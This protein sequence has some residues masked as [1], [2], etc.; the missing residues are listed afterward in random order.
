[1]HKLTLYIGLILIISGCNS[2]TKELKF[3]EVKSY[4]INL[5]KFVPDDYEQE[6]IPYPK[7]D[8]ILFITYFSSIE[9]LK[10]YADHTSS[11]YVYSKNKFPH[12][13]F[14]ITLMAQDD[15]FTKK[16]YLILLDKE[17]KIKDKYLI[18]YSNI[19]EEW[20]DVTESK[21][22]H[23]TLLNTNKV[24]CEIL[25]H[26]NEIN[27]CNC[28]SANITIAIKPTGEISKI[29]ETNFKYKRKYN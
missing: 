4:K 2:P 1:M 29:N 19:D 12:G 10:P 18:A 6:K 20:Y 28:D 3:D 21:I 15:M 24:S 22:E 7:I 27:Y 13:L 9:E 14:G 25:S 11:V 16:Y 23:D 5:K 17:N 8:S 26:V